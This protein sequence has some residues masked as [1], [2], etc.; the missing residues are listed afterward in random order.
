ME[1]L[2]NVDEKNRL[3]LVALPKFCKI[4]NPMISL[5][6]YQ[7]EIKTAAIYSPIIE[8]IPWINHVLQQ[9]CFCNNNHPIQDGI[10]TVIYWLFFWL[11]LRLPLAAKWHP[12]FFLLDLNIICSKMLS[13][14]T[15]FS[16][17]TIYKIGN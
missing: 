10:N 16:W 17:Y 1:P 13:Y 2:F 5:S 11:K 14:N 8:S 4:A 6:T 12:C 7:T 9:R 15:F 3:F